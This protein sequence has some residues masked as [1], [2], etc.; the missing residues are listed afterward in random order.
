MAK[1]KAIPQ[2]HHGITYRSR[3][4][5]R[6]A[7]F[8]RLTM[9][10]FQ[11]ELEG[12]QL[13]NAWYVP[14]FWLTHAEAFF[15]V[16]GGPPT[17]P[18]RHKA[19][20]LAR[21]SEY[22]VLVACGNPSQEVQVLCFTPDGKDVQCSI[23]EEHKSAGAWVARFVDGGDWAFSLKAGL[24][25]CAAYGYQHPLLEE[26]GRLQ[27]NLPDPPEPPAPLPDRVAGDWEQL[28]KF[29]WPVM[30][31]AWGRMKRGDK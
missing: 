6:W 15:E 20:Q 24:V 28:R 19:T 14:D 25:N 22:P 31:G 30:K 27:F 10:P 3:T 9:T 8:F 29:V 21:R 7:E 1:L 5:A 23:V 11:Y 17:L 4:E 18:E 13:G 2:E 12:Y 16:K 26:A